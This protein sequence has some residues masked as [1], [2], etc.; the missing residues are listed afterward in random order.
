MLP[1]CVALYCN[2]KDPRHAHLVG[3]RAKVPL[4]DRDVPIVAD[5]DV[6]L[7]F[8][9][10]LMMVCTFGD[11]ED[12]RRWKRDGLETRLCISADGKMTDAAGPYA[13]LRVDEAR[14]RIVADLE[15]AGWLRG[16]KAIEQT[17]SVSERS[18]APVEFVMA[19]QWFVRIL[20]LKDAALARSSEIEWHP[21]WMKVRLD[22]WIAGLKY[23]WNISRQRYYGVPFPV[24]FCKACGELVLA[25]ESALPVD[26]VEAPCPIATCPSCGNGSFDGDP[27]VMDTWMTSSMTALINSNWATP[28]HRGGSEQV[29]PMTVRVQAFEII[30]TWLFYSLLKSHL[31]TGS[32]PWRSVMISGWGLNEN[33]KK[34]S[35]RDLE[36]YTDADG[37]NRYEPYSVIRKYGA[38]A[39]RYWAAGSQL[40]HDLRFN[41]RDVTKGRKL[42]VKLWNA[43]RFCAMQWV[44]GGPPA[45]VDRA[46]R[47]PEDRW[48]LSQMERILPLVDQSFEQYNY[49]G[50]RETIDQ[51]FWSV[52]C[53]DYVE[54][55][56]DRFWNVDRY[57]ESARTSAR[58]TLWEALRT[59]LALYAPFLPFV[60][61]TLYQA[62]YAPHESHPSIHVSPWPMGGSQPI[63]AVPEMDLL[64]PILRAVR[65]LRSERK[66]AQTRELAFVTIDVHDADADVATSVERLRA[67]VQA[68]ARARR[69][70]YGVASH[71]TDVTGVRIDIGE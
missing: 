14:K 57:P 34:I 69:L 2:A 12:V 46:S 60:T 65:G 49:A 36:Q 59:I 15:S 3:G 16:S 26:P 63:E 11:G 33:G 62:I 21:D 8:G 13:M 45:E 27:D 18:G 17:I 44:S 10:G 67:S 25:P 23:D 55:V 42:V 50:A 64:L 68:L 58:A 32:L 61:E 38:D 51:F 52:F 1:A 47:T 53:D 48:L 43:A 20:D 37:F 71:S 70:D 56:K 30:R 24:W 7:D 19:P 9:S 22:H 66:I 29:Y 5:D 31:H 6:L 54:I 35:K 40:G 28:A 4:A 41:E 39:L